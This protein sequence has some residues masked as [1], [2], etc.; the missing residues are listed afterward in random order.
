MKRLITQK[1]SCIAGIMVS[2]VILAA[3][4]VNVDKAVDFTLTDVNGKT[5]QLFKYLDAGKYVVINLTL[6]G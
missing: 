5:H 1:I 6:M 3:A 4:Q 2:A